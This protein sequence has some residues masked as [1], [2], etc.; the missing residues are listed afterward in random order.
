[1]K[2]TKARSA[3]DLKPHNSLEQSVKDDVAILKNSHLMR[4][5]L[6]KQIRGFVFDIQTGKLSE[7]DM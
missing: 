4:P 2:G 3:A 7:V 1:M 6:K 5:E